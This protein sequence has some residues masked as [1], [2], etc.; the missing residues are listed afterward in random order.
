MLRILMAEA[1]GLSISGWS[2]GLLRIR[3]A[4]VTAAGL[5]GQVW[6]WAARQA[7]APAGI[8]SG[9]GVMR[10]QPTWFRGVVCRL[11]PLP[12]QNRWAGHGNAWTSS[13]GGTDKEDHLPHPLDHPHGLQRLYFASA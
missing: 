6:F 12:P 7:G 3:A 10:L 8:P 11:S 13:S 2:M 4:M 1:F 9:M 5:Q